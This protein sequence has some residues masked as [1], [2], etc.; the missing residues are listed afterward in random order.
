MYS[1][2][3]IGSSYA[4]EGLEAEENKEIDHSLIFLDP[5]NPICV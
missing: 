5:V 4:C 2:Y 3:L 1:F